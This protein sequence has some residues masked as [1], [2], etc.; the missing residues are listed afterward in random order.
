MGI[1]ITTTPVGQIYA[2]DG[3]PYYSA[4]TFSR[5]AGN[6]H[7]IS[8]TTPQGAGGTRYAFS[9]WSDGGL[10]SHTIIAPS[11]PTTYTANFTTQYLLT[12][13]IAPPNSGVVSVNP[14]S[15]DG[16]YASGTTVQ[17][18]ATA[19]SG[20]AFS[21]W[22]GGLSGSANLPAFTITTQLNVTATFSPS[23]Q[24]TNLMLS[25]GGAATSNHNGRG[26]PEDR[27]THTLLQIQAPLR[28]QPLC[29]A[30]RRT[31]LS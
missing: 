8:T 6:S 4:Q 17:L 14:T 31:E 19:N 11:V 16:Y 22:S 12:N 24:S 1:T 21:G 13:S 25:S 30:L 20:Y 7:T 26:I 28:M 2:V 29:S 15:P 5:V 18:T 27:L 10:V 23:G 3:V 9:N